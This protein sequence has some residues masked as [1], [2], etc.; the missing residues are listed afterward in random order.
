MAFLQTSQVDPSVRTKKMPDNILE[1]SIEYI[2]AHEVG[3][4]LGLMHNC[5]HRQPIRLIRYVLQSL[6]QK[7]GTTPSI[8]DY[9]RFN[10]VAQPEDKG[11]KLTPPNLGIYDGM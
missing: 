3:H 11:V 6:L 2:V 5:R 1:E 7:Y 9:A 4:T 8:M 10:Y